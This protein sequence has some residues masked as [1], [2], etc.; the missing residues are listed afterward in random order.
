MPHKRFFFTL[1]WPGILLL[2]LSI[3]IGLFCYKDYGISWDEP[4]QRAMGVVSYNY[5]FHHDPALKT[6]VDRDHGVGFELVLTALEKKLNLTDNRGI[7]L[8]RHLATH[9]FFLISVFFGYLLM[10]RLFKNQLLSCLGFLLIAFNPRLYAHSFFNTKDIPFLSVFIICLFFF[11]VAF[12]KN[13]AWWYAL[14]GL[15]C[16]YATSIRI[17]GVLLIFLIGLFFVVDI[18][19]ALRAKGNVFRIIRNSFIFLAAACISLVAMWPVLWESPLH[20][21]VTNFR[22]LS[23]FPW[24]GLVLFNGKLEHARSL[25]WYYLPEWFSITTPLLW[26]VAGLAG[27]G[28]VIFGFIKS[29]SEYLN[30]LNS[31]SNLLYLLCFFMPLVSVV[32]LHSVVYDDWRHV[33]FIYPPFVLLALGAINKF[34][35]GKSKLILPVLCIVQLVFTGIFMVRNH[36]YQQVYFNQLVSQKKDN[37]RQHFEQ[38]YW[39]SAFKQGMEYILSHDTS[40][41]IKLDW[42]IRPVKTNIRLFKEADRNRIQFVED[43][44]DYFITTFRSHPSDYKYPAIFYEVNVQNSCIMRVYKLQTPYSST[45]K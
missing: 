27:I 16:G 22:S 40:P 17:L 32:V 2:C 21:F 39:G 7:Y 37:I 10:Q 41:A 3:I 26:L 1:Y 9:L 35:S 20:N 34:A 4:E 45:T 44:A 33:Y 25:P 6:S 23:H 13:K 19:N 18:F 38:D 5:I 11:H 36:P 15:A 30:D 43:S 8:M 31:R 14:L 24:D 12:G 42:R 28:F 29:P